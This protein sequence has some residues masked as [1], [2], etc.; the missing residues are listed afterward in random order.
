MPGSMRGAVADDASVIHER[1]TTV[2]EFLTGLDGVLRRL[3]ADPGRWVLIA[4][5][6]KHDARYVQFLAREDGLIE[7][8]VSSNASLCGASVLSAAQGAA[9]VADGWLA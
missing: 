8:E 5:V 7:A 3:L 2:S 6:L 4:D 9:L 1:T